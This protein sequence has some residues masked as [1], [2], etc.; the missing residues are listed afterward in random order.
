M[1]T[2]NVQN[3]HTSVMMRDLH[4]ALIEIVSA[5]NR[6][7]R[8]DDL[9][10]EAG[11]SLDRALFRLLVAIERLGP[12]G[13]VDLAERIGLDYTTVSRQ[14][15]KLDGLGLVERKGSVSDRRVRQAVIT[16]EGKRMTDK[17]DAARER[18]SQAIFEKWEEKDVA[19]L[20]RLMGRFAEAFRRGEKV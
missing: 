12:I 11:I 1:S 13:V 18:M 20:V 6:P 3:T 16:P 19:D 14:V 8:D 7:Q 9:V 4:G 15:A 10:R 17:I 5:M 2:K